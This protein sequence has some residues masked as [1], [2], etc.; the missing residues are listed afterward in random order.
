MSDIITTTITIRNLE[1]LQEKVK[2]LQNKA[3][4]LGFTPVTI[5]CVNSYR[6]DEWVNQ[7][8][9]SNL[10]HD[11]TLTYQ[12]IKIEG[13]QFIA[14]I[15]GKENMIY[16]A[17]LQTLPPEQLHYGMECEHCNINRERF[18]VYV[19]RNEAGL[20]KR[21]GSSCLAKYLGIDAAHVLLMAD[22]FSDTTELESD[23]NLH[24]YS[25]VYE[26]DLR[27]IFSVAKFVIGR[28]GYTSITKAKETETIAT[29]SI[30]NNV[31]S[32]LSESSS[33]WRKDFAQRLAADYKDDNTDYGTLF[34]DCI[35]WMLSLENSQESYELNLYNIAN[36]GYCTFKSFGTAVSA[37][38]RFESVTAKRKEKQLKLEQSAS[39][40]Y[41]IV[42]DKFTAK[43]PLLA[44]CTFV[45]KE[46]DSTL[47]INGR[48]ISSV[49]QTYILTDSQGNIFVMHADA[50]KFAQGDNISLTGVIK[51]HEISKYSGEKQTILSNCRIKILEV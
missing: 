14:K 31:I 34:D 13:W 29:A 1:W 25:G 4:K 32:K 48:Y 50:H 43:A 47:Y 12:I 42:G 21:V 44:L 5:D 3:K 15:D 9:V 2:Q 11:V 17:P 45:S 36:N 41:G 40:F 39:D 49:K 20:Y 26:Y 35:E 33:H 51:G 6:K 38:P 30:V 28:Y 23:D 16:C 24:T 8:K 10:Y 37:L 19:L 22:I 46:Y 27:Q 18:T 7:I